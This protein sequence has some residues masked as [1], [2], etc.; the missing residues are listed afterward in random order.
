MGDS[1]THRVSGVAFD[2]T[3][4]SDADGPPGLLWKVLGRFR[5]FRETE[6]RGAVGDP[7]KRAK[8]SQDC[9]SVLVSRL[10]SLIEALV[11]TH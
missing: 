7:V 3:R 8:L 9:S 2:A 4:R 11:F 10:F 6:M 5:F 1:T